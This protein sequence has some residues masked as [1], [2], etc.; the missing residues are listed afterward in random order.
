MSQSNKLY[1]VE[2]FK[3][4]LKDNPEQFESILEAIIQ[5]PYQNENGDL[6]VDAPTAESILLDIYEMAVDS[7][8]SNVNEYDRAFIKD[9]EKRRA[10]LQVVF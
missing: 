10:L 4:A 3:R 8:L 6:W 1:Y 9:E 7:K 5:S 2:N